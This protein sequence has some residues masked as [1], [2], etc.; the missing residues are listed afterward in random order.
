VALHHLSLVSPASINILSF[1]ASMLCKPAN[2][3]LQCCALQVEERHAKAWDACIASR[4]TLRCW[5]HTT[6]APAALVHTSSL[7][8]RFL[9]PS[10]ITCRFIPAHIWLGAGDPACEITAC[11]DGPGQCSKH[12]GGEGQGI[13]RQ[14]ITMVLSSAPKSA[15]GLLYFLDAG[16]Q[17][18][19]ACYT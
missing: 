9:L 2:Q 4:S 16:M 11:Y 14:G 8:L 12:A 10:P 3:T 17:S 13:G 6:P 1:S 19:C 7:Q 5:R 15:M 18:F